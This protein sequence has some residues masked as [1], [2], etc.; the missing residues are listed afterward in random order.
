MSS[1][2]IILKRHVK[3]NQVDIDHI[4]F[5][6]EICSKFEKWSELRAMQCHY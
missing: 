4:I 1:I 5:N 6:V 3:I 2:G